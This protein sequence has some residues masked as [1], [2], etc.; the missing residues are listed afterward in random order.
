MNLSLVAPLLAL[1]L[2]TQD[3]PVPRSVDLSRQWIDTVLNSKNLDPTDLQ[4]RLLK[5]NLSILWISK[6]QEYTHGFIGNSFQ[7]FDIHMTSVVKDRENPS[8]YHVKGRTRV[9]LKV[10]DFTGSFKVIAARKWKE[11]EVDSVT[12]GI[13]A[14]RYELREIGTQDR[15]GILEG[16]AQTGWYIDSSGAIQYDDL[17]ASADGFS[18]NE[19]VGIW[20]S[21]DNASRVQCHWGDFR[22]PLSGDLDNGTGDFHPADKYRSYGWEN[23]SYDDLDVWWK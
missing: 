12:Q 4:K 22:I 13:F 14:L 17:T 16:Y 21:Y 15:A 11:S 10:C 9:K 6:F 20:K 5:Q 3:K 8:L 2:S 18:N 7:R 23:F 19:F 1:L